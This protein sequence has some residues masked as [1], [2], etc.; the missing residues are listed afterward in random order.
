MQCGSRAAALNGPGPATGRLRSNMN[1]SGCTRVFPNVLPAAAVPLGQSFVPTVRW[2]VS[3]PAKLGSTI[4]SSDERRVARGDVGDRPLR[5][6]RYG[7]VARGA[8]SRHTLARAPSQRVAAPH[9]R[10]D[11]VMRYL[12]AGVV[13]PPLSGPR[14]KRCGVQVR[15]R[16]GT[17]KRAS[18]QIALV[19]RRKTRAHPYDAPQPG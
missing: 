8:Y 6:A 7:R 16:P 15:H 19:A 1:S 17:E 11:P 18:A 5:Q 10:K 9:R 12:R 14:S 3:I 4:N 13:T 2:T